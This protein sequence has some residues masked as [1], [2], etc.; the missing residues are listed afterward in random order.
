MSR[1]K[2]PTEADTRQFFVVLNS[3]NVDLVM[4]QFAGNATFQMP[5]NAAPLRGK[6]SIRAFLTANFAAYPDWSVDVARVYLSGDESALL[7]TITATHAATLAREDGRSV[8]PTGRTS[9]QEQ[10]TRVTFDGDARVEFFRA[11]GEPRELGPTSE[12]PARTLEGST[13]SSAAGA[14]DAWRGTWVR[15]PIPGVDVSPR[16]RAHSRPED[17]APA[18]ARPRPFIPPNSP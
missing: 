1:M 13:D 6:P 11:Y 10:L 17:P 2:W 12:G 8:A 16:P 15:D 14:H 3:R 9:V 5:E 7:N 4:D 18:L